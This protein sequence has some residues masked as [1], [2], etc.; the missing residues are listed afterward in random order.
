MTQIIVTLEPTADTT[1]IQKMINNLKG[2]FETTV[3]ETESTDTKK[4]NDWID[5]LHK[6][7]QEINPAV[8][9]MTDERTKYIMSK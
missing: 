3:K 8:I 5:R 1:L 9:D 4:D 2:V 7:K 6:L